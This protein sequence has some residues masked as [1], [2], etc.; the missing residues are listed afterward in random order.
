MRTGVPEIFLQKGRPYYYRG[1]LEIRE[2]DLAPEHAMA[3]AAIPLI[4]SSVL[5]GD[6]V[7]VDGSV[8][9]NTPLSPA[10]Q[11]GARRIVIISR[12]RQNPSRRP[13]RL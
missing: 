9:L 6:H 5:I 13:R 1:E 8:R 10:I 2:V 7:Y 3:S 12:I 11:L 4:F